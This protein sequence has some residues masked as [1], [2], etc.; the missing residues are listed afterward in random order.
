MTLPHLTRAI[1]RFTAAAIRLQKVR[2]KDQL[3]RDHLLEVEEFFKGQYHLAMLRFWHMQEY[4]PQEAPAPEVRTMEAKHP[5][6]PAALKRWSDIWESI[7]QET[8]P[9]LQKTIKA[10]EGD[11]LLKGADQL[12]NQLQFDAKTTFSLSNPRAV[13]FFHKTGGSVDYIRGIQ[14]TTAESL[15]TVITTALD[16]GWSY[17]STAR[18]IQ[19]L[20]DG[21]ISRQRAQ[22]IATNESAQAYEAGNRAFAD[23]IVEDGIEM[24]K[25]WTTSH[26]DR[27]SDGCAANEADGWIPIDQA[28]SSGDQEPPRF[29]GCRCYEQYRQA[30]A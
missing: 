22:L 17:N 25:M 28:H 15:K 7:E 29:P 23:T 1:N 11:A 30:R 21:P 26:D 24:E 13:A 5:V 14:G 3:A 4:F 19:K 20:Y 2:E 8:T 12:R 16:E 18:E 9:A 10:I 27:V 6:D